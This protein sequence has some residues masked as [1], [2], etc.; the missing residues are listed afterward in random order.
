MRPHHL[1]NPV[2]LARPGRG[3]FTLIELLVSITVVAILVGLLLPA[4]QS[5]R[6]AA[7]RTQCRNNLRQIGLALHNY[8]D[9]HGVLPPASVWS[10]RGEPHGGGIIP[11]G[12]FDR[13]AA[14]ISP[15]NEPDRL[16]ANWLILLLPQLG[17]GPL[18]NSFDLQQPVDADANVRPRGTSLTVLRCP[19]DDHNDDPYDRGALAGSPGRLYARG[20]YG[21]NVFCQDP[22]DENDPNAL[23]YDSP[24]L[25]H[26]NATAWGGGIGGINR[27][28][29]FSDIPAGLSNM[30]GVDEIRAGIH[31][32]DP[33][34]TWALGMVGGSLTGLNDRGPNPL[35]GADG[36]VSCIQLELMLSAAEMGRQGMPCDSFRIPSNYFASARSRHT[37]LVHC[38]KMDGSVEAVSDSIDDSLWRTLHSRFR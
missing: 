36:I 20:N 10:G 4:V 25:V 19:A 8:H 33:R 32:L 31:P 7:R 37:G 14:G 12:A 21:L 3:G 9:A 35:D 2:R 18:F 29:R 11:L 23:Q 5:A 6:Q 30:I 34:G 15:A 38:L 13:V 27:S 1:R 26:V 24:D 28:L 16:Y 22:L 17:E